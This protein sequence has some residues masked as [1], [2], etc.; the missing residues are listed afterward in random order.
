MNSYTPVGVAVIEYTDSGHRA[1]IANAGSHK[2]AEKLAI[3]LNQY[4]S[5]VQHYEGMISDL[6]QEECE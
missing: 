4:E 2:D 6:K 1:L 5:A 3:L